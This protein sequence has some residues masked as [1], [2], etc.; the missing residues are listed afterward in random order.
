[1]SLLSPRTRLAL[2]YSLASSLVAL[3][4]APA[5]GCGHDRRIKECV[6]GCEE[7]E[8]ECSRH[9]ERGCTERAH[10]CAEECRKL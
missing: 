4:L 3:A 1:M 6:A 8:R 9:K 7:T 2:R 10:V 5:L